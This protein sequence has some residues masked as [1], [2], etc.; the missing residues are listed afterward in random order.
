MRLKGVNPLEQHVEKIVVSIVAVVVL[1]IVTWQVV[2]PRSTV[3]IGAKDVTLDQAY[4]QIEQRARE[5]QA[6]MTRAEPPALKAPELTEFAAFE[7]SMASGVSRAPRLAWTPDYRGPRIG[8]DE[9]AG[10]AGALRVAAVSVPPASTPIAAVVMGSIHPD[11][12]VDSLRPFLPPKP[13]YDLATVSVEATFD[14]TALAKALRH[15][16]DGPGPVQPMPEFWWSSAFDILA[17]ELQRQELRP[18]GTWSDPVAVAPM[19]N[20][21]DVLT[22]LKA[23]LTPAKVKDLARFA[24]ENAD[25]VRRPPFYAMLFGED[26]VPPSE[27]QKVGGPASGS[28]VEISQWRSRYDA[29][30]KEEA[31]AESALQA[32]T[33]EPKNA[34]ARRNLERRRDTARKNKADAAARLA[35]LGHPVD[36]SPAAPRTIAVKKDGPLLLEPAI[37]L[38][39]HDVTVSRGKT[40]RYR[41]SVILPNPAYGRGAALAPEMADLAK[42][43]VLR[44]A[45]SPWSEPVRVPDNTY[46][47]IT[48]A[49]DAATGG[50]GGTHAS[51]EVFAFFAGYWRRGVVGLEPGD[52]VAGTVRIP[53][54]ERLLALR[55]A[56]S[57]SPGLGGGEGGYVPPP[58]PPTGGGGKGGGAVAPGAGGGREDRRQPPPVS[59]GAQE[60]T[61]PM[62]FKQLPVTSD[63]FLLD[64]AAIP[65]AAQQGLAGLDR[66]TVQFQAV[67]RDSDGRIAVRI[68]ERERSSREYLAVSESARKGEEA[69]RPREEPRR[70]TLPPPPPR[71]EMPR[72]GPGGGGGGKGGGGAGG[73]G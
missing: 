55:D 32:L 15:D 52:A 10:A 16:P 18:D 63:A 2:G 58:P 27:A 71:P 53:D 6:R 54:I 62:T 65:V 47:F 7:R 68:P 25:L 8:P 43:P 51:A 30:T 42:S 20:R 5:A 34:V 39:S 48:S 67:L 29:A 4:A 59:G 70:P 19:P 44:S 41:L 31:A 21:T 45:D 22:E 17:V 38:W 36:G 60:P 11:E 50:L 1:G 49:Q 73:G 28:A 26:W 64:V 13:P 12:I 66:A 40:Y 37:R 72:P 24:S 23:S 56:G 14:G 69:L 61:E 9:G 3:K 57:P 33:D 35:E 46:W